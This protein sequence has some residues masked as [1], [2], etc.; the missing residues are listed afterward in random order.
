MRSMRAVV[1]VVTGLVLALGGAHASAQGSR[2]GDI[3]MITVEAA[4]T[5]SL[6]LSWP[7]AAGAR[8][9]LV[10]ASHDVAMADRVVVS[11][12]EGNQVTVSGLR[13]GTLHCFQVR[14]V[15]GAGTG[16]RSHRA[17]QRTV[18]T[19]GAGAGPVYRVVTYNICSRVCPGWEQRREDAAALVAARR[20]HVVLLT[21][22]TVDSGMAGAI[23]GME[24]LVHKSGK[25]LLY[26][27][28]TFTVAERRGEPRAGWLDLGSH[29]FAAWAEL[30]DRESGQHVVFASVHLSKGKD[31]A[32]DAQRGDETTN[33]V[34]GLHG[35]NPEGLP[36]VVGG[37]FNSYEQR[38]YDSA[39][40]VL[41]GEGLADSF[42]R[43]R[44]W[45]RG[46]YDSGNSGSSVPRIGQTWGRHIDQVWTQPGR[47][48]VLRWGNAA[49]V[50]DGRYVPLP[51]NHN[52]V[53]VRLRVDH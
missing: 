40:A 52:P 38:E 34:E 30:V 43:A 46:N 3:G 7:A 6:T 48:Q 22:A 47:T 27:R 13:P 28:K 4:S 50:Q 25:A 8:S 10:E 20:P 33:L 49:S 17:C 24:Q 18:G 16:S 51:S 1:V 5:D 19:E 23:G 44:T 29:R 31:A 39:G 14:G 2:P 45:T 15:N 9:Y 32:A 12:S 41:R 53:F 26:R 11:R 35:I 21:E 37:D 42:W 36:L